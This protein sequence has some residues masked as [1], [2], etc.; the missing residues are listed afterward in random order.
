MSGI[1]NPICG[2]VVFTA[3]APSW[4]CQSGHF[5]NT[6]V[7]TGTGDVSVDLLA[8]QAIDASACAITITPR[9]AQAASGLTTFGVVHTSDVRKQITCVQEQAGGAASARADVAFDILITRIPGR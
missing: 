8:G 4:L 7:D 9:A 3:G 1:D 6:I 2:S 5:E